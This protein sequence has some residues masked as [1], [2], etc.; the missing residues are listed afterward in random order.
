[1]ADKTIGEL[2][3][4]TTLSDTAMLPVEQNGAAGRASG[5]QWKQYAVDSVAD[6]VATATSAADL[7]QNKATAA[8]GS[9]TQ[10]ANSALNANSSANQAIA[11]KEKIENMTVSST[12][13]DPGSTATVVKSESGGV[14]NIAFGIPRGATGAQGIQGPAGPQG[15]QG[16]KGDTGTAVAVPT[17]G[18]YYF[19]VDNN[20]E[21][22]SYGHLFLTY[23]G[24]SAPD[25]SI[26]ENGHL[27]WT[28]E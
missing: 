17:E 8:A 24:D 21:S 28:V 12:T 10:A 1:M 16:P 5:A 23:T 4:I 26:D 9:A 3:A 13:L 25:F 11:A 22:A 27:I 20:S 14:I 7:A 19:A 18:M 2:P 6:Q 15:I